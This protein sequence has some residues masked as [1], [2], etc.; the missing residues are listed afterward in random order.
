MKNLIL[1]VLILAATFLSPKVFAQEVESYT[2]MANRVVKLF[3][4]ADYPGLENLFSKQLSQALPLE[5]AT[6]FFAGMKAQFGN[7]QKLDAPRRSAGWAVFPAHFERGL[8]D[9]SLVVDSANKISGLNFKPRAASAEAAPKKQQ[10]ADPYPRVANRLIQL[11]NAANYSGVE[12][13][14]NTEMSKALP[15]KEATAFFTGLSEQVG[16]MQKLEEPKRN[17]EGA[18]FS[19]H[20]ER[21][22]LDMALTLDDANKIAGVNF[23]PRA[24]SPEAPATQLTELSLPFKGRWFVFWG[25]DTKE[26]N[27]HHDI[28][29]QRF[30]FDLLG[31]DENGRTHRG[32]G[33]KN[34]DY[35]CFG[36]EILAPSD[37]VV[38]EAIDGV[39]DNTPGS[40]NPYCLVGNCVVIQHRTNE[41]SVLAHF[42]RGSVAVKAGEPVKR[43]QLIG[44]CG[45]SGNSSEPHLHYQLQHSPIFQDALGIKVLFQKLS[46]TKDGQSEAKTNYSPVKGDIIS[47][48]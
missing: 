17:A 38:V 44:K 15:L 36:R 8:L 12:A 20:C 25:G 39:R 24:G 22:M 10:E 19:V 27:H 14:F 40:M 43:G 23:T 16:K 45:N 41:F 30:A 46:L 42:Q 29:A 6:A 11:I 13:L 21:G 18:V 1:T 31:A 35:L 48:E 33:T 26:L 47:P 34:E 2:N 5:K 28:P 37:G 32:D 7:M 9:M 3:N 4:A